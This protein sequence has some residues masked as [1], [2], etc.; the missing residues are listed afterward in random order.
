MRQTVPKL[1]IFAFLAMAVLVVAILVSEPQ[2]PEPTGSEEVILEPDR[3]ATFEQMLKIGDNAIYVENQPS[4]QVYVRV[5]FTVLSQS[6]YVII[7]DDNEGVPGE[8]IG[9]SDLLEAGGEHFIVP[10]DKHLEHDQVY[11]AML[12]HDNGDG[13]FRAQEDTQVVDAQDS[14]VLMT[15]V[16]RRDAQPET[17]A[18][19]P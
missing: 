5:G 15:F 11:Y 7:L 10:V 6:G 16:A 13:R 4:D 1:W 14:V 2:L 3:S 17:E 9:E 18:V 19:M 12:Y 8:I